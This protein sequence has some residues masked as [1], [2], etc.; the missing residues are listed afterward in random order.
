MWMIS[1]ERT[2]EDSVI[3]FAVRGV[4]RAD[5]L[6]T[7]PGVI[8]VLGNGMALA[9]SRW[10]GWDGFHEQAWITAALGLFALSGVVWA[11]FLLRYQAT[12]LAM[13]NSSTGIGANADFTAVLHRWYAWGAVAT[14]LPLVSLYLMVTKPTLWD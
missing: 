14:L 3:A 10:G 5:Y 2:R 4:A 9:A 7:G 12:M 11:G 8:L 1:A 6:F 13:A